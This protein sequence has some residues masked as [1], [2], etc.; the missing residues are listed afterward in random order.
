VRLDELKNR[1]DAFLGEAM[2]RGADEAEVGASHRV[3]DRIVFE[4]NDFQLASSNTTLTFALEVHKDQCKGSAVTNETVGDALGASA[5]AAM[6]LAGFSLPDEHL[7]FP[8]AQKHDEVPGRFDAELQ[9]LS[10]EK[11]RGFAADF[12][13]AG[14]HEKISIDGAELQVTRELEAIVNSKGL[15]ATDQATQL[16]WVISGM[17]K[18]E[19]E[20]TS[21]DWYGGN[22]WNWD[23]SKERSLADADVFKDKLLRCF[24]PQKGQSYEGKVLLAPAV[25]GE[26][27]FGPLQFHISGRQ[28][29]DGKSRWEKELGKQVASDCLTLIDDPFDL[30]LFSAAPYDGEGVAKRRT[31]IIEKGMLKTHLDSTY[32]AKKRGTVSTGHA[33]GMKGISVAPGAASID[34]LIAGTDK[35]VVVERFSGN[36]NPVTGDFSGVAK[37]SHWYEKGEYK[38][39]LI[40]TMIAGNF[41]DLVKNI[42]AVS[43]KADHYMNEY[44]S[45]WMLV[46]GVSVTAS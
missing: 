3:V 19:T 25:L 12:L 22:A 38:H 36:L 26:L 42:V 16:S 34:E 29:M 21:F 41:F 14:R 9:E 35:L 45:P 44:K 37:G 15:V 6:T 30:D 27:I 4:K 11:L 7:C 32:S 20:V 13:A 31:P 24:N 39:P 18:T 5:D 17:G 10:P 8:E 28:I 43:N 46:D 2:Q 23:G 40:E 1:A 33:G